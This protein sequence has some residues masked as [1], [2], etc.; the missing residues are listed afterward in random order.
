MSEPNEA[1]NDPH[2]FDF[3]LDR[4]IR[5]Q[6]VEKLEAS[7]LLPLSKG[8]GPNASGIYVL[9]FKDNLVYIERHRRA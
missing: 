4:G 5:Q 2:H 8:V 9:Y 6:V 3:D 7:P 1:H